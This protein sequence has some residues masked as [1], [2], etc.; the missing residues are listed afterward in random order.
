MPLQVGVGARTDRLRNFAHNRGAFAK[1][2][3]FFAGGEGEDEC[4]D[5]PYKGCQNKVFFHVFLSFRSELLRN[6]KSSFL[7]RKYYK[8]KQRARQIFTLFLGTPE[9]VSGSFR[10]FAR[11][12]FVKKLPILWHLHPVFPQPRKMYHTFR[13]YFSPR[14]P[15]VFQVQK[16]FYATFSLVLVPFP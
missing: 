5:R 16:F 1:T 2:Q 3:H 10:Y 8:E 9:K 11:N 14:Y 12:F 13:M 7:F 6:S 4:D 15:T